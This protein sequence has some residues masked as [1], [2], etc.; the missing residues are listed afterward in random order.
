MSA[1]A[2]PLT[3]LL[4]CAGAACD[5]PV[6]T[7]LTDAAATDARAPVRDGRVAPPP[8][9]AAFP[10]DAP[11]PRWSGALLDPVVDQAVAEEETLSI[12]IH[13]D[14][15][16]RVFVDDA[17]PGS[18]WDEAARTLT[19]TPDFIQGA[20]AYPVSVT[21]ISRDERATE[22]FTIDV[23][24]T[25]HPRDPEILR[26]TD[27]WQATHIR[28]VQTTDDYLDPPGLAGRELEAVI[29]VPEAA[30]ADSLMPMRITLHAAGGAPTA[31][32]G[33]DRF[34][35]A[36]HNP[37]GNWWG[38]RAEV[39]P[40]EP[41]TG[42]VLDY[43]QRRVLH[44]LDWVTRNYP[45]VDQNA[46]MLEG[47]S[48]GGVGVLWMAARHGR[49]FS[50]VYARLA[51]AAAR[52][53]RGGMDDAFEGHMGPHEM[54]LLTERG[55][56]AWDDYDLMRALRDD[57][58]A[59]SLHY[60]VYNAKNDRLTTF[61]HWIQPSPHTGETGVE[62]MQRHRVGHEVGWD[63]RDHS[64]GT[65]FWDMSRSSRD[66]R[67]DRAFP[68]FS[69]SSADD[70]AGAVEA[71]GSFSG[72]DYG[73]LNRYFEWTS[74][75]IVD[76]R[77]ALSIP[78]RADYVEVAPPTDGR[79]PRDDGYAGATP[80]VADVTVRRAARFVCLP[81]ERVR[82][83]WVPAAGDPSEGEVDAD[84]AGLVTVPQLPFTPEGGTLHLERS[85][86]RPWDA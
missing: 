36:P 86:V 79:P 9:D 67:R 59:A 51:M 20:R 32:G 26:V 64:D 46:I 42:R 16:A 75:E 5:G 45:G 23:E 1:R 43:S 15:S 70:D 66:V 31:V 52:L 49:H 2:L 24:D 62:A 35:L 4:A 71:D 85:E 22:S 30:S 61:H 14:P 18:R 6:D 53:M 29:T 3:F 10:P 13:A 68:A 8:S 84:E 17:P 55:L 41:T 7:D 63:Q 54:S 78:M 81:G 48:K 27:G 56:P 25:I 72:D 60:L 19:F 47:Q 39:L 21:A 33:P 76:T 44:L 11:D 37:E 50:R 58:E 40:D 28:V 74:E 82:W 80:I 57:P 77:A 38:G 34:G 12:V 65:P 69:R 83:R 73:V